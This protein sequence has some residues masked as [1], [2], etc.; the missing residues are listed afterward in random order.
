MVRIESFDATTKLF[1]FTAKEAAEY[2]VRLLNLRKEYVLQLQHIG[3][4]EQIEALE[5]EIIAIEHKLAHAEIVTD[6][7]FESDHADRLN[8][9]VADIKHLISGF[10]KK[11]TK[12]I[13]TPWNA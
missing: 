4:K 13:H 1:Q 10:K 11:S 8:I 2:K 5:N 3:G 9:V 12:S 7:V 6:E